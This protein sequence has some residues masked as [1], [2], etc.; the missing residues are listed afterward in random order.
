MATL[1]K[2]GKASRVSLT[3]NSNK[4]AAS[5]PAGG[6]GQLGKA[7]GKSA[8]GALRRV[9]RFRDRRVTKGGGGQLS[10]DLIQLSR[11]P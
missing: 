3:A 10:I 7:I 11:K 9:A 8:H 4:A 1:L 5:G 2:S 6:R